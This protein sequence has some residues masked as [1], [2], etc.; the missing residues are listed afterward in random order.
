[1]MS[2][3]L[4]NSPS[5]SI[6]PVFLLVGLDFEVIRDALLILRGVGGTSPLP[7]YT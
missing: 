5:I 6:N 2:E 1:M 4:I 3:R 7:Q